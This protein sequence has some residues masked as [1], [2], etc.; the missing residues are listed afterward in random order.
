MIIDHSLITF[1]DSALSY[2][3]KRTITL[4]KPF[5]RFANTKDNTTRRLHRPVVELEYAD[6]AVIFAYSCAKIQDV[7]HLVSK[8][9]AAYGLLLRP[10]KYEQMTSWRIPVSNHSVRILGNVIISEFPEQCLPLY[11]YFLP[12]HSVRL[13]PKK[14]RRSILTNHLYSQYRRK[15]GIFSKQEQTL[16]TVA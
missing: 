4:Q 13:Y 10:D 11:C 9:A 5:R 7:V 8:L 14:R 12:F 6:D 16:S 3:L 15:F 2:P 1:N